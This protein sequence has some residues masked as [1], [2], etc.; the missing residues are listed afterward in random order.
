M[1]LWKIVP[2]S[3]VQAAEEG[4]QEGDRELFPIWAPMVFIIVV[5]QREIER[6]QTAEQADQIEETSKPGPSEPELG[7]AQKE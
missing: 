1:S 7:V 6:E 3:P 4:W 2:S 5:K